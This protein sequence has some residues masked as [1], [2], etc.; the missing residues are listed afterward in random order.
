M[1]LDADEGMLIV[2][3]VADTIAHV[4]V[5]NRDDIRKKLVEALP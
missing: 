3:V 5:L 1:D 2:D 4:E